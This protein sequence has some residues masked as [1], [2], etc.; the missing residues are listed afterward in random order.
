MCKDLPL[1]SQV[2]WISPF[3]PAKKAGKVLAL[4]YRRSLFALGRF[5]RSGGT[6][7]ITKYALA[8]MF[9]LAAVPAY[10]DDIVEINFSN[11]SFSG[12]FACPSGTKICAETFNGSFL[13][14]NTTSAL[15]PNSDQITAAGPLGINFSLHLAFRPFPLN[16][17]LFEPDSLWTNGSDDLSIRVVTA[18]PA[19]TIGTYT[20]VAQ[21]PFTGAGQFDGALNCNSSACGSFM[22]FLVLSDSGTLTV[23]AVPEPATLLLFGAGFPSLIGMALLRRRPA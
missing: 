1:C 6:M 14:D 4:R 13:W 21:G 5:H 15:V 22:G 7:K 2:E 18:A 11:L 19:Y 12:L 10:A 8:A 23:T 9:L 17:T 16:S 3:F 20:L